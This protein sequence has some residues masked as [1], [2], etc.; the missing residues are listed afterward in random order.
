MTTPGK[1]A[2]GSDHAAAPAKDMLIGHLKKLG[3]EVKDYTVIVDGKSD[4]PV[5]G[6][7]VAVAVA[8]GEFPRGVLL[9]GT[10]I[11]ISIVAN[12]VPGIRAALCLNSESAVLSREHNDANI[13]VLPGRTAYHDPLENILDA[14]LAT[15]FSGDERHVRR[16][17]MIDQVEF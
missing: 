12:R 4:Y 1:I 13:L 5:V 10:G 11:G 7:Q 2:I 16:I 8:Q 17:M 14:W 3:W 15:P 9:C 6:R